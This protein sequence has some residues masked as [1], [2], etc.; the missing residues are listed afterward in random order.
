MSGAIPVSK[1]GYV[2]MMRMLRAV[3]KP[4]GVASRPVSARHNR[5][6]H[7]LQ[8]LLAIH[9][10]DELIRLDVP[11][12]TYDAIER[13]EDFLRA[14][15]ASRVFEYGSGAST[16][17]LAKRADSVISIDHDAGWIEFS[18]P[19]LAELGNA[20]VEHVPADERLD[21]DGRYRSGKPGYRDTSFHAYVDAIDRWPG[22]FDLIV[23]DGRARSACLMKAV[24]RLADD[25]MIVFDN[26]HRRRYREAIETCGLESQETKGLVPSLPFPDQTTLLR[27]PRKVQA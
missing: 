15:K 3:V 11:W 4:L 10:I 16:V 6:R 20:T 8:S 2:A 7:W 19:R 23:V 5:Y 12:W 9:D 14:R 26:S 17:W 27:P 18:R 13:V 25:G 21:P 24:E 22:Q 1:R